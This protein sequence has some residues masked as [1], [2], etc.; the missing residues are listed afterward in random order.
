MSY[1]KKFCQCPN[2]A[3]IF[4]IEKVEKTKINSSENI[5]LFFY[6]DLEQ[7]REYIF[8]NLCG[9]DR[10]INIKDMTT[11]LRH[12]EESYQAN[13]VEVPY[14]NA[15]QDMSF[16]VLRMRSD[17]IMLEDPKSRFMSLELELINMGHKLFIAIPKKENDNSN[18]SELVYSLW[19]SI[20][21]NS[22]QKQLFFH[23]LG[24]FSSEHPG[25][26]P[27][28]S[29]KIGVEVFNQ[30]KKEVDSYFLTAPYAYSEMN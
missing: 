3:T 20:P 4:N 12:P 16:N 24:S 17:H 21:E 1:T 14:G 13:I 15:I 25:R 26:N 18:I 23:Y 11:G 30:T 6:D 22:Y 5:T 9:N 2:H 8:N 29:I 7:A 27:F 28:N 19:D 10:I